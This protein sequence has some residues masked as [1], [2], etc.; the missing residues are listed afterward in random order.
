MWIEIDLDSL[1]H[2]YRLT[3][4]LAGYKKLMPI[5]KADAYGHGSVMIARA[6][7]GEG[8]EIFAVSTAAEAITLRDAGIDTPILV[9]G[10]VSAA[11]VEEL[12]A[13]NVTLTVPGPEIAERYAS[14]CGS[15]PLGV[16]LKVNTGMNRLGFFTS[17]NLE[18][19]MAAARNPAFSLQGI[20]THLAATGDPELDDFTRGQHGDFL[21]VLGEL[22]GRGINPRF[23]HCANSDGI[24]RFPEFCGNLTR[25]G[26]LLYGYASPSP[27]KP[28]LKPVASVRTRV[29]Q[30]KW[31]EEGQRVGYSCAWTAPRRT[32]VATVAAGYADG[33][34]RGG[35][36]R[37][38]MII[39][40]RRVPQIG[41]ICMDMCM[42]DVSAVP[43]AESGDVVT[44]VGTD[45]AETIGMDEMAKAAG[46]ITYEPMTLLSYRSP[47]YYLKGGQV[48]AVMHRSGGYSEI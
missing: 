5:I 3:Q 16:Q 27:K 6:C 2:N 14:A 30:V 4:K 25:P 46:T 24:M 39:R 12:A 21:R 10:V 36:G 15:R 20:F 9:L 26:L 19:I 29:S 32:L 38:Q 28:P 18:A 40:G 48:V 33:I 35:S 31:V 11:R 45:G 44:I 13:R 8:A 42:L 37:M 1:A 17:D 22:A 47:R 34:M 23:I 43:G 41:N 7:L